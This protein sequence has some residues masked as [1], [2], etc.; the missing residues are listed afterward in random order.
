MPIRPRPDR[1]PNA[2]GVRLQIATGK[3]REWVFHGTKAEAKTFEA[4]KKVEIAAGAPATQHRAAPTFL[5]F[6]AETY[7]PHAKTY[8]RPATWAVRKYQIA[9]LCQELG[10]KK[11]TAIE[12]DDVERYAAARQKKG[13]RATT[14]NGELRRLSTI[15]RYARSKGYPCA[16]PTI[17]E[18]PEVGVRRVSWWTVAQIEQLYAAVGRLDPDL[19]GLVVFLINTGCR[20]GEALALEHARVDLARGMILIEPSEEWQPKDNEPR[21]I[22]ISDALWPWLE[23]ARSN[24]SRFVFPRP[25]STQRWKKWPKHRFNR[26]R[27]AAG[28]EESCGLWIRNRPAPP[29]S[30]LTDRVLAV[31]R[32][33]PTASAAVIADELDVKVDT[34][35]STLRRL[36]E[37][38]RIV[39]HGGTR[40]ARREVVG[41]GSDLGPT[42]IGCTCGAKGLKGGPYTTRHTFASHFLR[43]MPDMPLLARVMGHDDT[44]VTKL[45]SHL[46]PEHLA[47]SKNAVNIGAALGPARVE[48]TKR[49]RSAAAS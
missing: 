1:G 27:R 49:W 21:E 48:A 17:K 8:L 2:W 23:R 10:S 29:P 46:L 12:T 11:L 7:S 13:M 37:A 9:T 18:L 3:R 25:G 36:T 39:V 32:A 28:H 22:V 5:S 41:E 31:V 42:A 43:A 6:C 20:P 33:R 40:N 24:G 4:K 14:I 38:G 26:C 45:Y 34:V 44:R 15:L 35:K 30:A 16:S 19:L 47:A